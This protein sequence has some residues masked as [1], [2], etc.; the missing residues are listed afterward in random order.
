MAVAWLLH[1]L[2]KKGDVLV[3]DTAFGSYFHLTLLSAAGVSGVFLSHGSTELAEV[4]KRIVSFRPHRAYKK[5][6]GK[7][8][9]GNT[10]KGKKAKQREK[11]A[12]AARQARS[13]QEQAERAEKAER[14]ERGEQKE[15]TE[16]AGRD[17]LEQSKLEQSKAEQR[18]ED[19]AAEKAAGVPKKKK[20]LPTSRWLRHLGKGDQVVEYFKPSQRPKWM[21]QEQYD[22]APA[23]IEVREI[24]RKVYLAGHRPRVLTIVTTLLDA[25][26]YPAEEVVELTR[27]RWQVEVNLR[28]LKTTMGMEV[29]R[30]QSV[31]GVKK[32]LWAFLLVYNLVQVI[33]LAAALRQKAARDR[34]SFA[35]ALYWVRHADPG[36]QLPDLLLVPYRPERLEPRAVKR[37]PK[38]YDRLNKPRAVM[39][40][41]LK[42]KPRKAKK[43]DTPVAKAA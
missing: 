37:R 35:D 2:L 28:H 22:A 21:T 31:E 41:Q 9:Q 34:V 38:E 18:T 23:S 20:G 25:Q 40:R 13:R 3:G 33:V 17:K 26:K 8:G 14:E 19:K 42:R 24:R 32:E 29:L 15:Q 27:Q 5:A 7:K 4:Q 10:G 30:C 1:H 39:R 16:Q 12:K 36:E 11:Q 43:Q 6:K